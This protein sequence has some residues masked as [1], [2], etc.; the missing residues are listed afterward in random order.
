MKSYFEFELAPYTFSIIEETGMR[1]T[2]KS[3]FY[4]L[5]SPT[6]EKVNLQDAVYVVDGGYLLHRVTWQSKDKFSSILQKYVDYVN[7]YY[8]RDAT[9]VYDGYD[10]DGSA[11]GTKSCNAY[12]VQRITQ[13]QMCSLMR[14][15]QLH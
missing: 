7:S 14:Q 6:I 5:F 4:D 10:T 9:I 1:K 11:Q 3:A 2:K 13:L 15:C 12:V 8:K